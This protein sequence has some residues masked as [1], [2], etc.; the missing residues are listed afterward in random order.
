MFEE[1]LLYSGKEVVIGQ[2]CYTRAKVV[3][4]SQKRLYSST[5][6]VFG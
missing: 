6:I 5:A 3:V 2:S 1:K 4:F